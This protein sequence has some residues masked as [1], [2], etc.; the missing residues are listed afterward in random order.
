MSAMLW[1]CVFYNTYKTCTRQRNLAAMKEWYSL[2]NNTVNFCFLVCGGAISSGF[3][4]RRCN[5]GNFADDFSQFW[6]LCT[7]SC[8]K[9]S[10]CLHLSSSSVLWMVLAFLQWCPSSSWGRWGAGGMLWLCVPY[11]DVF[12]CAGEGTRGEQGRS[13]PA[14]TERIGVWALWCWAHGLCAS[15][16]T[17]MLCSHYQQG[18]AVLRESMLWTGI[19]LGY[20]SSFHIRRDQWFLLKY[21]RKNLSN[22]GAL[23]WESFCVL[24]SILKKPQ[25]TGFMCSTKMGFHPAETAVNRNY[26]SELCRR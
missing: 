20:F 24:L 10:H 3:S 17:S 5:F 19:D 21:W 13:D 26:M 1:P 15:S 22:C 16:R 23:L 18:K 11:S 25:H 7:G 14:W 8:R 6:L 4:H 2:G 9:I 12:V